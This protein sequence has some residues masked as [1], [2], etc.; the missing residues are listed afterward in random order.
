MFNILFSD[1]IIYFA[2]IACK[3]GI[4]GMNN[5]TINKHYVYGKYEDKLLDLMA[6]G[7]AD[8]VQA[9]KLIAAGADINASSDNN[10]EN[11]LSYIILEYR[12]NHRKNVGKKL[13]KIVEYF[14]SKGFDVN[15]NDGKYGASCLEAIKFAT[16]DPYTIDLAKLLLDAGA[17]N[18]SY[19]DKRGYDTLHEFF[20]TESSY[21]RLCC[22]DEHLS[23]I[24]ESVYQ[25]FEAQKNGRDYH[26]VDWYGKAVGQHICKVYVEDSHFDNFMCDL[27][28]KKNKESLQFSDTI[29]MVLD[30]GVLIIEPNLEMWMDNNLPDKT[31]LD[32]SDKFKSIL[33]FKIENITFKR[34]DFKIES[35]VYRNPVV[36]LHLEKER[37][38]ALRLKYNL[39]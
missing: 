7:N 21:Q 28:Y 3:R 14:L 15:K 37:K 8:F 2:V 35:K 32:V 16:Y 13:Y 36:S 30:E 23:N 38:V 6:E 34:N 11:I 39:E 25:V 29:Y 12:M 22:D 17:R 18:V 10:D 19:D 9:D 33:G 4:L 1:K 24:F 31:V 5:K 27:Y 20:S 26:G